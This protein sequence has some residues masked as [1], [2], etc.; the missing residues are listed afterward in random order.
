MGVLYKLIW[1]DYIYECVIT[2]TDKKVCEN[3]HFV[4]QDITYPDLPQYPFGYYSN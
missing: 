1:T 3:W 4:Y 2:M